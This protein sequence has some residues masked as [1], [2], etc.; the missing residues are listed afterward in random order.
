VDEAGDPSIFQKRGHPIV[1]TP[2]S[3]R[4]FIVGKLEVDDPGGLADNLDRLRAELCAN[5]YFAGVPAFDPARGRAA[6]A[7]H[8][9]DDPAEVRLRVFDL[10]AAEGRRLRFQAVV[11]DKL[12]VLEEV[13]VR[14]V[15][16]SRYTPNSLYD[17]LL[18]SLFGKFHR[19]ADEYVVTI[20][21][22]GQSN[23]NAALQEALRHA[24]ADFEARFG[25]SR[26]A[27][28]LYTSR[29][30]LHPPL[31]AVDYFLWA[32]QRLYEPRREG[33][34]SGALLWRGSVASDRDPRHELWSAR[35]YVLH[36][37]A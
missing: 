11:V 20:A 30:Y 32:L 31:Q 4:F 25:F 21:S 12:R 8:A 27:W 5:P 18:R 9:K 14:A 15:D 33:S 10:L 2:G 36:A 23:R 22:R 35:R 26:G 24:E 34:E 37:P 1:G 29:P 28:R 17:R 6:V 13:R 7:F 3:S 19:M 16:T